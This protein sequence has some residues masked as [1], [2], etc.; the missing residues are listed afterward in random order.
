M[1]KIINK[2]AMLLLVVTMLVPSGNVFAANKYFSV[3][4]TDK[5]AAFQED[6]VNQIEQDTV[7]FVANGNYKYLIE[8]A[9]TIYKL[10]KK[11]IDKLNKNIEKIYYDITK[12][13][14]FNIKYKS[15][16]DLDDLSYDSLKNNLEEKFNEMKN[17]E[18]KLKT[19]LVGPHRDDLEFYLDNLN[20]KNYG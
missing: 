16:I 5:Y 6:A 8:K 15:S 1:K 2:V 11:F 17:Q 20:L 7:S 18:L 14:N 9:I 10:R 3:E 12:L 4:R 19:T 13:N